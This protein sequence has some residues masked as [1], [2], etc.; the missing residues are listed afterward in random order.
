MGSLR[1]Y[2]RRGGQSTTVGNDRL[3]MISS[4]LSLMFLSNLLPIQMDHIQNVSE[5]NFH[6]NFALFG[7]KL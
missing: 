4:I 1:S 2:Y 7:F 5:T 6:N 3:R